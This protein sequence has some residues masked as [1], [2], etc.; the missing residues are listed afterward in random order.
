[1]LRSS[2]RLDSCVSKFLPRRS[3]ISAF[4]GESLDLLEQFHRPFVKCVHE[5]GHYLS[6]AVET[7]PRQHPP[8]PVDLATI[9]SVVAWNPGFGYL[10]VAT[11]E[12]GCKGAGF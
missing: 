2:V 11:F 12:S 10:D 6:F 1:M 7:V 5:S 8:V 4:G 9:R 3:Q